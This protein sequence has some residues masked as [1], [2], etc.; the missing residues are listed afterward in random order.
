VLPSLGNLE[1]YLGN[2]KWIAHEFTIAD[3]K[4]HELIEWVQLMI[5]NVLEKYPKLKGHFENFENIPSIKAW[6]NSE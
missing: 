6:K 1:K 2:H 5:P 4:V 3:F